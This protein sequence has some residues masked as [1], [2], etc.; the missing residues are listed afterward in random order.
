MAAEIE[1]T[2]NT[3]QLETADFNSQ[4][5]FVDGRIDQWDVDHNTPFT[6][7][8]I[9]VMGSGKFADQYVQGA[10][11]AG[12]EIVFVVGPAIVD[13]KEPDAVR[14]TAK[15]LGIP[16]FKFSSRCS[17]PFSCD[18]PFTDTNSV[19][20]TSNSLRSPIPL[21]STIKLR[22]TMSVTSAIGASTSIGRLPLCFL[23]K[24]IQKLLCMKILLTL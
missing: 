12:H 21:F 19:H 2:V 3:Q 13:G 20:K 9:G 14:A 24:S 7:L 10:I 22:K 17:L 4:Y 1:G 8:K 15:N 23:Y 6:P 16:N 11:A 5:E 18:K